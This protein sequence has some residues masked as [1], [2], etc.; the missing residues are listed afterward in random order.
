MKLWGRSPAGRWK[1]CSAVI[2]VSVFCATLTT[3]QHVIVDV[4][5]G[6]ALA[7]LCWLVS[8]AIEKRRRGSD[9]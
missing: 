2:A 6:V 5:A 7:E 1:I 4:F 3:K 9:I 8:G